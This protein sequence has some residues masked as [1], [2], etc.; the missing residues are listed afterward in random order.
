MKKVTTLFLGLCIAGSLSQAQEK[1]TYYKFTDIPVPLNAISENGE[2]VGGSF[3]GAVFVHNTISHQ[4][5][6]L[7][8]ENYNFDIISGVSN[9][10]TFVGTHG[11][12]IGEA[13]A[14]YNKNGEWTLLE[15]LNG[16]MAGGG[17][18]ISADSK[19]IVGCISGEMGSDNPVIPVVWRLQGDNTYKIE[20]LPYPEKDIFGMTSQGVVALDLT[21][22]GSVIIGRFTDY[23]SFY[24]QPIIWTLGANNTYSY[25]LMGDE[26]LYNLDQTNPGKAFLFDDYVTAKEGTPEYFEQYAEWKEECNNRDELM[27]LF[28]TN[29]YFGRTYKLNADASRILV[30]TKKEVQEDPEDPFS[31]YDLISPYCFNLESK[32]AISYPYNA[33]AC[34]ITNSGKIIYA[35]PAGGMFNE[36]FIIDEGA[37]EGTPLNE[38]LKSV[39]NL[40]IDEEL[41]IDIQGEQKIVTGNVILNKSEKAFISSFWDGP[42]MSF[43]NYLVKLPEPIT[44]TS[45]ETSRDSEIKIYLNGKSVAIEGNVTSI[46]LTDIS[47]KTVY[48]AQNRNNADLNFL[49]SGVYIIKATADSGK[50][51]LRKIALR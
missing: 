16:Y 2:W 10:G 7:S 26:V 51:I 49:S 22:D 38:W 35:T 1:A 40:D 4:T 6:D 21:F 33:N 43:S 42:S 5:Q 32:T 47:G 37:S 8:Q 13:G 20:A 15:T 48:Q 3:E 39:Y 12:T 34:A 18:A 29:T 27:D 28:L 25:K 30:T 9:D 17:M 11:I 14:A 36:A 45:I 44:P 23:T 50:V 24:E 19:I 41:T 46:Q 31:V